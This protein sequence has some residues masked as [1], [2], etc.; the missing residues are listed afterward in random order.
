MSPAER[1][2]RFAQHLEKTYGVQ[3]DFAR[4]AA[5]LAELTALATPPDAP[6]EVAPAPEAKA[7]RRAKAPKE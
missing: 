2:E 7:K 3:L 6:A 1:A 5:L 4:R